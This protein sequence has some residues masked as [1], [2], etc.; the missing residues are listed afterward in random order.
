MQLMLPWHLTL[1]L[2]EGT[3]LSLLKANAAYLRHIY[4]PVLA[5]LVL[6]FEQ[7]RSVRA[8]IQLRRRLSGTDFFSAFDWFPHK[9]RML[10]RHGLPKLT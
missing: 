2:I 6:E 8:A 4:F 1:L 10:S 3:L 5:A 7:V 9:L